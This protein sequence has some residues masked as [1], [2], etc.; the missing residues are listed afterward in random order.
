M[1]N[2]KCTFHNIFSYKAT[3]FKDIQYSGVTI[4]IP[5]NSYFSISA[6]AFYNNSRPVMVAISTRSDTYVEIVSG[7]V[8][9]NMATCSL[10][11]QTEGDMNMYVWAQF[12]EAA[13][14]GV[15]IQGFYITQD[16]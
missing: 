12:S 5:A 1:V 13:S 3:T 9:Y 10:S 4:T 15:Q 14:N 7:L 11:G 2:A 16:V 8:G 6:R